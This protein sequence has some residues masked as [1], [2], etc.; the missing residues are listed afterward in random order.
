MMKNSKP[1]KLD[2]SR[3]REEQSRLSSEISLKCAFRSAADIRLI[4]GLDVSYR[5][6]GTVRASCCVLSFPDLKTVET[7]SIKKH[8]KELFPYIPGLLSF[9]ELPLLLEVISKLK[10]APD[11]YMCDGQG[12]AHPRRLGLASHLGLKL[13]KPS[14]GCAKSRLYGEF[15]EP[16]P[17]LKGSYQFL[18]AP[19]GE[20]IGIVLRSRPYVKPIFVS[21][22]HLMD[23]DTAGDIAAACCLKYRIPEPTR[24]AHKISTER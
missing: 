6:G 13:G 17:G 4:A 21:P 23:I 19:G 11:V 24:L 8:V 16:P 15:D 20:L 10:T 1:A 7:A 2:T 5:K 12:I 3:F 14:L 22:G 9:R 18:K